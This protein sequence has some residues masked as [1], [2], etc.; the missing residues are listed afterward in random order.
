MG[1]TGAAVATMLSCL[2]IC[3]ANIVV[4]QKHYKI[5]FMFW[6]MCSAVLLLISLAGLFYLFDEIPINLSVIII[7]LL[8]VFIKLNLEKRLLFD[9]C[10]NFFFNKYFNLF[11]RKILSNKKSATSEA[12]IGEQ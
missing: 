8:I 1:V 4:S 10:I 12:L 3:F 5:D 2:L 6:R 7:K 9:R 11:F